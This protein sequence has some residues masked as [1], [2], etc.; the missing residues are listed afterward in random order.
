MPI[1]LKTSLE[2]ADRSFTKGN[3]IIERMC[4]T[5]RARK[6]KGIAYCM[7]I[8]FGTSSPR[9]REKYVS[10]TV[11]RMNTTSSMTFPEIFIPRLYA[12][13]TSGSVKEFAAYAP[14]KNAM[15]VIYNCV[16]AKKLFGWS[17]VA[18]SLGALLSPASNSI[19]TLFRFD[20]LT[21]ISREERNPLIKIN[22]I[23]IATLISKIV[24][25]LESVN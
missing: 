25:L 1:S 9:I 2:E 20:E 15:K 12:R 17:I 4:K 13:E 19:F 16:V 5:G 23:K 18:R 7:A 22:S 14:E 24:S 21:A 11:I 3:A 8:R 6:A 10:K